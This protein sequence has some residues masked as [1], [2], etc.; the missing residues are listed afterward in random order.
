MSSFRVDLDPYL[1]DVLAVLDDLRKEDV[2]EVAA[3][4]L[5][6]DDLPIMVTSS[7]VSDSNVAYLDGKPVFAWGLSKQRDGVYA[8]WGFGTPDTRKIIRPLT[9][10][11]KTEWLPAIFA[12]GL[13]RRIE[14]HVPLKSSHSWSWLMWLG[15]KIET[16][17]RYFGAQGEEFLLL[18]YTKDEAEREYPH[19]SLNSGEG[20]QP[21]E[22]PAAGR[23]GDVGGVQPT[24]SSGSPGS[25][26]NAVNANA[27]N[28]NGVRLDW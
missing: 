9:R 16:R 13:V 22:A 8:L 7:A 24:G 4:G 5:V 12:S 18:A 14:V 28:A 23:T 6:P 25:Y 3:W 17:L 20:V 27:V 2:E 1:D 26:P 15:C 10:F 11:G 19:V 21:R